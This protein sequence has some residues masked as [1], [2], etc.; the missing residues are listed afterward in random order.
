M[1]G[2]TDRVIG[3][4]PEA[5]RAGAQQNCYIHATITVSHSEVGNAIAVQV[6]HRNRNRG[7]AR[8]EVGGSPETTGAGAQQNR[9]TRITCN[10]L[11]RQSEVGNAIP[12]EITHRY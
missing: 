2:S 12:V 7:C 4:S 8:L 10:I 5:T 9:Y 11:A 1:R 6:S 3:G